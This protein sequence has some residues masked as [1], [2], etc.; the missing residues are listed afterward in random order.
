MFCR[1]LY[2]ISEETQQSSR[3]D[4]ISMQQASGIGRVILNYANTPMQYARIIKRSTQD[5][6]AGRGDWRSNVSKIVYYGAVQNL[7]FNGL[8]QALFALAFG[9]EEEQKK[10]QSGEDRAANIG[11]GMLSSLLRGL[12]Y[13]GALVDTL[14][15]MGR[16][17]SKGD[18]GLPQFGEDFAWNIFDF[19]PT[20]DTKVRKIR[21]VRK[22]FIYMERKHCSINLFMDLN[23]T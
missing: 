16:E 19:S 12:G 13:G 11:F 18:D 7:I 20:V 8:Q 14:I 21:A 2:Q 22:T 23:K 6:L 3:T 1:K 10:A 4:R 5:L 15:S 17:I 9:D